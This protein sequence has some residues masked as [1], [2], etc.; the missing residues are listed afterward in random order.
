MGPFDQLT[1]YELLEV[2]T[3]A[4]TFE[5]RQAYKRLIG[6]YSEDALAT[7]S[8][9]SEEERLH[10]LARIETAFATLVNQD[11]R[12]EYNQRLLESGRLTPESLEERAKARTAPVFHLSSVE[13]ADALT[14][15]LQKKLQSKK[16]Q[17]IIAALMEKELISG[18]DLQNLRQALGLGLEELFQITKI[19][20]NI[21][22]AIEEDDY[23]HLPPEIYV[24]SFLSSYAELLNLDAKV[25]VAR[26]LRNKDVQQK[27]P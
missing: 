22:Q 18:Q 25:V 19:S 3:S 13:R 11:K 20:P 5:I 14:A 1:Y 2:P 6:I 10:I 17:H 24:K 4:S 16:V 8:L 15:Q 7:Y 26:Y 21:L 12:A 9:F 23:G 27:T